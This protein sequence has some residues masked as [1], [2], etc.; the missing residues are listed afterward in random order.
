MVNLFRS[1]YRELTPDEKALISE[2]KEHANRLITCFVSPRV[3][4]PRMR[5]LA[6]TNLEQSVMWAVKGITS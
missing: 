5:S 2:I 3:T 1:E 6:M 4:D